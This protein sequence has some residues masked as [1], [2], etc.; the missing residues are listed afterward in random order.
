[1]TKAKGRR[2]LQRGYSTCKGPGA[3]GIM[4]H[5]S[6]RW[7]ISVVAVQK[8]GKQ[9]RHRPSKCSLSVY[10]GRLCS[11]TLE[12]GIFH[13]LYNYTMRLHYCYQHPHFPDEEMG[14]Q[15]KESIT[16]KFPAGMLWSLG[17]HPD[18]LAPECL[19]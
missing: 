17:L 2:E 16:Q 11:Q 8:P 4:R 9:V 10:S 6:N 15:R 14:T 7:E 1:M 5:F 12:S 3:G 13:N 18:S 19:L